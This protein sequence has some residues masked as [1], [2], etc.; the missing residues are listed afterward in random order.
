MMIST[1]KLTATDSYGIE[2]GADFNDLVG[3]PNI[4][5]TAISRI[6]VRHNQH[7]A[8]LTVGIYGVF[9]RFSLIVLVKGALHR[10]SRGL[11]GRRWFKF[12]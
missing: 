8:S 11:S 10:Q 12:Q 3:I 7:I 4:N 2:D 6:V 9:G 5:T 1:R